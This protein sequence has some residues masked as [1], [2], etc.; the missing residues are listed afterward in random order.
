MEDSFASSQTDAFPQK[1]PLSPQQTAL[2]T[3]FLA[4]IKQRQAD[5]FGRASL[6]ERLVAPSTSH[7]EGQD[8]HRY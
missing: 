4:L 8:W 1:C 7:D 5:I 2:Q 3:R 6:L